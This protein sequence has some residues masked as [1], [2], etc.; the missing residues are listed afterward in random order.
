MSDFINLEHD[1][2]TVVF[3]GDFELRNELVFEF[4]NTTS[5]A[6]YSDAFERALVLGCY[7]LRLNGTGQLLDKVARDLN[8]ELRQL[9]VLMDLQGL[10]ERNA[11]VAGQEAEFNII[12]TL[13]DLSDRHG[14]GDEVTNTGGNVGAIARRK[15]GDAVIAIS[16][17]DRRIVIESKADKSVS[18]GDPAKAGPT[19]IKK[20]S[21]KKTAYGEGLTALA[22]READVAIVVH[23]ADNVHSSIRNAGGIQFLAEQ[24]GFIVIVDRVNGDWGTL[25]AAY[26]L[27]R[28]LCLAWEEGAQRWEAVDLIVKKLSRELERMLQIDKQLSQIQEAASSI[29]NALESITGTRESVKESLELMSKACVALLA[30]PA[31]AKAKLALFN[32]D[33]RLLGA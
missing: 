27:A 11:A 13:Q 21:E 9:R 6:Q 4:F 18:L 32:D 14:W 15:V 28:G 33:T 2:R 3:K 23:F 24:P 31:D 16:G 30:N 26:G 19:R 12:D 25:T 8:G 5:A 20:N 7:A 1:P 29:L 10:K 17:T 22:N